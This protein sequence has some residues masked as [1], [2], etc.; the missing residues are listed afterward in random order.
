[1]PCV[2]VYPH[3]ISKKIPKHLPMQRR[4]SSPTSTAAVLLVVVMS[5]RFGLGL[6]VTAV[7]QL[8]FLGWRSKMA[9]TCSE[10][11]SPG[12]G[13]PELKAFV[14]VSWYTFVPEPAGE[15]QREI[16]REITD[17]VALRSAEPDHAATGLKPEAERQTKRFGFGISSYRILSSARA[18]PEYSCGYAER[19]EAKAHTKLFGNPFSAILHTCMAYGRTLRPLPSAGASSIQVPIP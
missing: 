4:P 11:H 17:L 7:R 18:P 15:R 19:A 14:S 9:P 13:Y 16:D 3:T 12:G 8:V 5:A 2:F 1:M 10:F 6:T